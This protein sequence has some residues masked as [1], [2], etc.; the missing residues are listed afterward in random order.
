MPFNIFINMTAQQ[1]QTVAVHYTG[2][3]ADGN[4]FDT[5]QGRE[6]I[7]FTIGSGQVIPGFETGVTGMAIGETKTVIIPP[8]DAYGE[9]TE[10]FIHPIPRTEVPEGMELSV[11]MQLELS[12]PDGN[13]LPVVVI[14]ITDDM[15]V[16][17]GNHP[18]AGQ[19]LHFDLELVEIK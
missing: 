4:V 10:E 19:D 9:W 11:G 2:K 16:L 13:I 3:F 6:P 1:G 8:V 15:I 12:D 7:E 5:S 18:L 14:E 17:D